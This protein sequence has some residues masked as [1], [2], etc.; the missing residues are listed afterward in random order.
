MLSA[1]L[2]EAE[3]VV[4]NVSAAFAGALRPQAATHTVLTSGY[5]ESDRPTIDRF[6][7]LERRLAQGWAADLHRREE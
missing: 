6:R 3:V 5:L 2:P 7:P 1:A 4:A